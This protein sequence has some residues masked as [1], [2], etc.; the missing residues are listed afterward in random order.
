VT[1]KYYRVFDNINLELNKRAV[2][3]SD[4]PFDCV[5]NKYIEGKICPKC[6]KSDQI[7]PIIYGLPDPTSLKGEVGVDYALGGCITTD[8]DADWFCKRDWTEF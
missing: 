5:K 7:I 4:F 6:H 1:K 8:C 3:T 2:C